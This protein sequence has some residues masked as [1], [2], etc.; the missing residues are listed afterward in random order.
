MI[1]SII[2]PTCNRPELLALCLERLKPGAQTIEPSMYEVIVTDD[3]RNEETEKM[4]LE[5]YPWVQHFKG[6]Q[7]GPA[8]NRNNGAK[9]AKGEWLVFTDD[10]CLP[11]ANWLTAY[12]DAIEQH[13]DCRAF[14]GAILPDDWELLKKDMAE[15]PVNDQGGC[16]WSANIMVEKALFEEI[17]GFDEQFKIAAME[18]K[19]IAERLLAKTVQKFVPDALVH[20]PVRFRSFSKKMRQIPASWS[21]WI[22]YVKKQEKTKQP[23]MLK[24]SIINHSISIPQQLFKG[25]IQRMICHG[26]SLLQYIRLPFIK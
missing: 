10:D 8:A 22:L 24:R 26:W 13:P 5:K 19:D 21:N 2:I 4:V 9:R 11:D 6:P 14:E 23:T 16:F 7:K 15:C 17:G 25:N 12:S 20:H 18:D 1:F 3:S